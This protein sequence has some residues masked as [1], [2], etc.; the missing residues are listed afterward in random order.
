MK[1]QKSAAT[2]EKLRRGSA[3]DEESARLQ[4]AAN[5]V[6]KMALTSG[7]ETAKGY[8][9]GRGHS[10]EDA[11]RLAEYL[12]SIER[13]EPEKSDDRAAKEE[14]QTAKSTE[15]QQLSSQSDTNEQIERSP[16]LVDGG[17][18]VDLDGDDI[19]D[20][21]TDESDPTLDERD[22]FLYA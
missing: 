4:K 8:L 13:E 15:S 10:E 21:E 1:M 18:G 2:I 17:G 5:A 6:H 3:R 19:D 11:Q 9:M 16:L 22:P 20:E 14:Q 7:T 12:D